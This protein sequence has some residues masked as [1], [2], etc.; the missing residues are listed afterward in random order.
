MTA[1]EAVDIVPAVA[2]KVPVVAP[3]AIVTEPCTGS[4][5]GLLLD[6]VTRAPPVGAGPE[7]VAVQVVLCPEP[8]LVGLQARLVKVGRGG[9]KV[10]VCVRDVPLNVPVMM[11]L[12]AAVIVPATAGKVAVVAPVGTVTE[13]GTGSSDGL[14]LV[15][16]T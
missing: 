3:A 4:N 13:P 12:L 6:S 8:R 15:S 9:V 16:P 14:L 1:E 10:M 5:D 11:T 2:W 7:S